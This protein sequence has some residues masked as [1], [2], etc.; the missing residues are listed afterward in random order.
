MAK[1]EFFVIKRIWGCNFH[2]HYCRQPLHLVGSM[3][4]AK[5]IRIVTDPS[6][7]LRRRVGSFSK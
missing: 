1:N 3:E 5:N 4:E 7:I 2:P 6:V